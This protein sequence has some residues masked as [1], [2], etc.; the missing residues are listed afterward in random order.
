M[1]LGIYCIA[2]AK[3]WRNRR[4]LAGLFNPLNENPFGAL[5]TTDVEI[6][7]SFVH[8]LDNQDQHALAGKYIKGSSSASRMEL[9][10]YSA[11]IQAQDGARGRQNSRPHFLRVGT[12][13]RNAALEETNAEAW[14]FA[15]VAFL[16]FVVMMLC[17][18][19]ASINRLYSTI[20][21]KDLIFGLNL[22]AALMLPLQGLLNA[23]V[24][25]LSSQSAVRRVFT[26]QLSVK[27]SQCGINVDRIPRS[28]Y[29]EVSDPV[30]KDFTDQGTFCKAHGTAT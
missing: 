20:R 28:N 11:K 16:F 7:S 8:E 2:L 18:T 13:T 3:A 6:V 22:A 4:A 21:P 10:H 19:P 1:A 12:L 17:W 29:V 24:Y 5:V 15:R 27:S 25:A 23:G 26:G 9:S 30:R 14:L